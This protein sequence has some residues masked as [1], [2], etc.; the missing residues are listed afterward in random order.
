MRLSHFPVLIVDINY[1]RLC[2]GNDILSVTKNCHW[3]AEECKA[4]LFVSVCTSLQ[5]LSTRTFHGVG[6]S[7]LFFYILHACNFFTSVLFLCP[8]CVDLIYSTR[9]P[10]VAHSSVQLATRRGGGGRPSGVYTGFNCVLFVGNFR[11]RVCF[12][13]Q[14]HLFWVARKYVGG[15]EGGG[16]SVWRLLE[17]RTDRMGIW[18]HGEG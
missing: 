15:W 3:R 10:S 4:P 16:G 8:S 9:D 2:T 17:C 7:K 18:R 13:P 14:R 12:W 5:F 1:C 11:W 6:S